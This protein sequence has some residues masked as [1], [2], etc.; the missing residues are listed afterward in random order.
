MN[1]SALRLTN[2]IVEAFMSGQRVIN[3]WVFPL[4]DPDLDKA[5]EIR[6]RIFVILIQALCD[7][8]REFQSRARGLEVRAQKLGHK[9]AERSIHW[10][11]QY[12]AGATDAISVF[13]RDEMLVLREMRDQYVHGRLDESHKERRNIIWLEGREFKREKIESS[14]YWK[15]YR[16]EVIDLMSIDKY[17]EDLRLRFVD[18]ECLFWDMSL[19]LMPGTDRFNAMVDE[20]RSDGTSPRKVTWSFLNDDYWETVEHRQKQGPQLLSL[21]SVRSVMKADAP[22]RFDPVFPS[23]QKARGIP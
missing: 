6:N 23:E 11:R 16:S 18:H 14:E 17:L 22:P 19:I 8:A 9:G 7:V 20:L 3:A 2:A 4:L 15:I 13:S 1:D 10:I 12:C 5:P 21:R